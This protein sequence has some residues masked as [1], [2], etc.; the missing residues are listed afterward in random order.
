MD[1]KTL[2]AW[3]ECLGKILRESD[4]KAAVTSLV[5]HLK[6]L[7][8]ANSVILMVYRAGS[9]PVFLHNDTGH[10]WR[11]NNFDD[12]IAAFYILDPFYQAALNLSED[13]LLGLEEI[14]PPDFHKSE[15][16]E[17][18]YQQSGLNDEVNFM[19]RLA[20]GSVVALSL[21]RTIDA[22]RFSARDLEDMRMI[23]PVV[24]GLM[25]TRCSGAH[26]ETEKG[27]R[28]H[29]ELQSALGAFGR[30][31]LTPREFEIMQMLMHG[32]PARSV[33]DQLSISMET[34][35]VHRKKIYAKLDIGT[36]AELFSLFLAA[37]ENTDTTL[38]DDPLKAY[39]GA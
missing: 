37:L 6:T 8:R 34:V 21:A 33:A 36:H 20:D 28:L 11:K 5:V 15:Y 4:D 35:K 9:S 38:G 29:V 31:I 2:T 14:T 19:A 26:K 12:Y 27:R 39:L 13:G 1:R 3:H 10:S 17:A 32:H 25:A 16:F 7:F 22:P 30:D 23:A 18:W 24:C